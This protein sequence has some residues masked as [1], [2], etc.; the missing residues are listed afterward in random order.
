MNGISENKLKNQTRREEIEVTMTDVMELAKQI[1]AR[2]MQMQGNATE[3]KSIDDLLQAADLA[4]FLTSVP[5]DATKVMGNT[6][7]TPDNVNPGMTPEQMQTILSDPGQPTMVPDNIN[8]GMTK[9]QLEM[10]LRE[11]QEPLR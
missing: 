1:A 3:S 11:T 8:P 9:E 5:A 4:Q 6:N 2:K 7:I 10:I